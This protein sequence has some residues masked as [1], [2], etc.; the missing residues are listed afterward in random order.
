MNIEGYVR[1]DEYGE[2]FVSGHRVPLQSLLWAHIEQ[3]MDGKQLARRFS[4][5]SLEKIYAVLA[6][7]YRNK[8][9]VDGYL[10]E[11]EKAIQEQQE[12]FHRNYRGP[13]TEELKTRLK[14]KDSHAGALT[15]PPR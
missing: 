15:G 11:T 14:T 1:T 7:Y 4:T 8:D 9:E 12:E 13:S 5:L 6:Y 3:G 2:R 10:R